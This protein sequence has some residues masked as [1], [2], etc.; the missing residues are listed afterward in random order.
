MKKFLYLSPIFGI[1]ALT[2]SFALAGE[3]ENPVEQIDSITAE[4]HMT[5]P[6][7]MTYIPAPTDELYEYD[8]FKEEYNRILTGMRSVEDEMN[9][10]TTDLAEM[11]TM[12]KA[13]EY[14]ALMGSI[15][16]LLSDIRYLKSNVETNT[17]EEKKL[18]SDLLKKQKALSKSLKAMKKQ[19]EIL[20]AQE[21]S[22]IES[23]AQSF[24][25]TSDALQDTKELFSLVESDLSSKEQNKVK[26]ALK[27]ADNLYAKVK[28]QADGFKN[29]VM[30]KSEIE[31]VWNLQNRYNALEYR[32]SFVLDRAKDIMIGY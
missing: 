22:A 24:V 31:D 8:Y 25:A 18:A 11:T 13:D 1:A 7:E 32:L 17:P 12:E 29:A 5:C 14:Q 20:D 6:D 10:F 4:I 19:Y 28:K 3:C 21:L 26:R 16:Y 27:I 30:S 2:S 15:E 9:G 23:V